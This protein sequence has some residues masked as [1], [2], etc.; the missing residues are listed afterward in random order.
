[1]VWR[2]QSKIVKVKDGCL[3]VQRPCRWTVPCQVPAL[4]PLHLWALR[5][6]LLADARNAPASRPTCAWLWSAASA[7]WD[8]KHMSNFWIIFTALLQR[9]EGLRSWNCEACWECV[10]MSQLTLCLCVIPSALRT[11]SQP[12]RRFYS[13]LSSSTWRR[14]WSVSGSA[15]VDRKRNVLT[16]PAPPLPC[17]ANPSLPH[18]NPPATARTWYGPAWSLHHTL[19]LNGPVIVS[20][21][22]A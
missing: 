22:C 2:W 7:R 8:N 17:P 19:T 20:P 4:C 21:A 9:K 13:S 16:P 1:M 3:F 6:C 10:I 11:R 12:Q 15:T 14:R 18:T 5:V